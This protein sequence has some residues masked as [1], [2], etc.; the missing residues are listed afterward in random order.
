[1]VPYLKLLNA[2]YQIQMSNLN[3]IV[4]PAFPGIDDAKPDTHSLADFVAEKP[5]VARA[6]QK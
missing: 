4:N 3:V 1:M 2:N 5:P 6:L